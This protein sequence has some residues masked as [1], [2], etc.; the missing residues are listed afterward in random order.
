MTTTTP[1]ACSVAASGLYNGEP[2]VNVFHFFRLDEAPMT[3]SDLQAIA[4]ILDD[5]STDND[6]LAHLYQRFDSNLLV[7]RLYLRTLSEAAPVEFSAAVSI[8]G[9]SAGSDA[10]PLLA[11]LTKWSTD[12]A[13]RSARGRTYWS[14]INTSHWDSTDVDILASTFVSDFQTK[15]NDFVTAWHA[16]ATYR[17]GIY[18]RRIAELN[19]TP[20]IREVLAGSVQSRLSI[21][22][23]RSPGR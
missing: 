21:Q 4:G 16:N 1:H 6:A 14:G 7:N 17:F 23:R 13:I 20:T 12:L 19:Q 8:A 5:A 15:V 9:T 11:C 18:S 3:V 10:Q 2:F 22:K